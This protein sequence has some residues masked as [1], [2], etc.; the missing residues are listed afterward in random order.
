MFVRLL[1]AFCRYHHRTEQARVDGAESD[2]WAEGHTGSWFLMA[3]LLRAE[4]VCASWLQGDMR[5]TDS[6]TI[7]LHKHFNHLPGPVE[8]NEA[9]S[10]IVSYCKNIKTTDVPA[11]PAHRPVSPVCSSVMESSRTAVRVLFRWRH[12]NPATL[13][14]L[15]D[16]Y[17]SSLS[18][19]PPGC[20]GLQSGKKAAFTSR[21][22][23]V[24][25]A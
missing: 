9:N 21:P 15:Q 19:R 5:G 20:S 25:A 16:I 8:K 12:G 17:R 14:H 2:L 7:H 11:R 23:S 24:R 13:G 6:H 4:C 1:N 3:W 10:V 18:T 22:F